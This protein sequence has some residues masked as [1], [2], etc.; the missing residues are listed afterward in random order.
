MSAHEH[1][2]SEPTLK[3]FLIRPARTA[4][5][6]QVVALVRELAL[7][8]KLPGPDNA[9]AARLTADFDAQRFDLLVAERG[10]QVVGYALSFMTYSTFLARPSLYLED[11]FVDPGARR[12]GIATAFLKELAK[13]ALERGCG[14]FEWSVLDWNTPAQDFYRSLGAE[15]LAEWR[16]CRIQGD[17][18]ATLGAS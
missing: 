15:V 12:L 13:R 9:A 14:R 5:L 7:F 2:G 4:D 6:P 3:T 1:P 16:I 8:E 10:G 17:N 18:L 11:L